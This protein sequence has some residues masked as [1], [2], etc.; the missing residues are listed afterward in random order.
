MAEGGELLGGAE[1]QPAIAAGAGP[2]GHPLLDAGRGQPN[3]LATVPRRAAHVLGAF[4]VAEAEAASDEP[5]WGRAPIAR[6]IAE[7][8]AAHVAGLGATAA[9]LSEAVD[10]G[11]EQL[12]FDPD[13]WVH[14]LA[15]A[16]LGSTYASPTRV[17]THI[18]GVLQDYV[19]R[20]LCDGETVPGRFLVFGTE[21]GAAAMAYV[22]RS[23]KENHLVR[24]GDRVA[25]AT[26]IFTPYLQIPTLE[27]FGFDIAELPTD[28]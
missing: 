17:L 9:F 21:G 19:R 20:A 11:V 7:R 5:L 2:S 16:S 12:G 8:L 10:Y 24:P 13:A 25:I 6:G 22:F 28:P 26:P 1:L 14:E 4:A 27:A 23:L 15:V 3:W 18:E